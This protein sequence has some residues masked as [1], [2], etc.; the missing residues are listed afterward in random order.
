M[1]PN[2]TTKTIYGKTGILFQNQLE[3]CNILEKLVI[4]DVNFNNDGIKDYW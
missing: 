1:A 2:A 4:P 3:T